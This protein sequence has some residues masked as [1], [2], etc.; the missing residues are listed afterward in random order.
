MGALVNTH[1][2]GVSV[3][4]VVSHGARQHRT[5]CMLTL[6]ASTHNMNMCVS[7]N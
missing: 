6:F 1:S 4:S 5:P 3:H 2:C 7:S